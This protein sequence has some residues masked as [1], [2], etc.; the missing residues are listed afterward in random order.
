MRDVGWQTAFDIITTIQNA[1]YCLHSC[2][3]DGNAVSAFVVGVGLG[4]DS[5][6]AYAG[7]SQ[8]RLM[9]SLRLCRDQLG[10]TDG[11]TALM[12]ESVRT[13]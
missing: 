4:S 11:Q 1:C 3:A 12:P 9:D 5:L 10:Q 7:I 8:D 2:P 13:D 6:G